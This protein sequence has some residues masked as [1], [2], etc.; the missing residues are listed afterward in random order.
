MERPVTDPDATCT[1]DGT[2]DQ[3]ESFSQRKK[4]AISMIGDK[5]AK[6]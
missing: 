1:D 6:K 2:N 5:K 3:Y 4:S